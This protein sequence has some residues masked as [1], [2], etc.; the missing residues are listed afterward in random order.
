MRPPY[1]ILYQLAISSV[2]MGFTKPKSWARTAAL[3]VIAGLVYTNIF[4][5]SL[6]MRLRWAGGFGSSS[7]ALLQQYIDVALV[8]QLDY[9]ASATRPKNSPDSAFRKFLVRSWYGWRTLWSWR[10]LNTQQEIRNAPRLRP[11]R[12][13]VALRRW[14]FVARRSLTAVVCYLLVDLIEN[15][16]QEPSATVL[17]HAQYV[18]V[19]RRWQDVTIEQVKLRFIA[20]G[21]FTFTF[22]NIIQCYYSAGSAIAV[23]SG[24]SKPEDW[25]PCFGSFTDAYSLKNVWG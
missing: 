22:F 17:F 5:A 21:M 4:H 15:A 18:P 11:A 16:P 8:S 2:V 12:D 1:T 23:A 25:R 10:H 24:I 13:S 6:H 9:T 20:F 3:P 14:H 7:F 19:C